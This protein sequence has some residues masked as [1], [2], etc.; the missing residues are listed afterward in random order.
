MN[1]LDPSRE[2][3]ALRGVVKTF[4]PRHDGD[5]ELIQDWWTD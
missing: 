1:E 5:G 2:A 3:I 4:G